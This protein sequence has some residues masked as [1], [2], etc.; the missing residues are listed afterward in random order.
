MLSE[1]VHGVQIVSCFER[2]EALL[3]LVL[4]VVRT[5]G[6]NPDKN[7]IVLTCFTCLACFT[8]LLLF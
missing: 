5:P 6:V 2:H 1:H 7:E 3:L 4:D 8:F